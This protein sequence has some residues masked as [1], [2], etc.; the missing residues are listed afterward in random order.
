MLNCGHIYHKDCIDVWIEKN[1]KC[2]L[3]RA[4]I[5]CYHNI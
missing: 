1:T 5:K 4:D 3:C 2:P